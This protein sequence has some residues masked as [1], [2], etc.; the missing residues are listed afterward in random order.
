[1]KISMLLVLIFSCLSAFAAKVEVDVNG[2]TCGM[3][4]DSITKELKAT[5]KVENISVSLEAKKARFEEIKGKKI[6]DSEVKS[7]IKKAG[8]EAAKITRK[9]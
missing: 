7:A 8:Y 6:S 9:Q 1:M 3:C 4:V 5:E 2:M